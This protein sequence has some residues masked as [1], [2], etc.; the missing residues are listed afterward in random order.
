MSY[1]GVVM[2]VLALNPPNVDALMHCHCG[3]LKALKFVR[4]C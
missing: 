3:F 4:D 2:I 1:F